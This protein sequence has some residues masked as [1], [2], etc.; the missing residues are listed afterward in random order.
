MNQQ[1]LSRSQ[2]RW[3]RLGLFLS[4][5]PRIKYLLGKAHVVANSLNRSTL[6][7][8]QDQESEQNKKISSNVVKVNATH[9]QD[10]DSE[11]FNL[12]QASSISLSKQ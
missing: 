2:T 7:T 11:F 8:T 12:I 4:I 1:I 5:Q 3:I 6:P 10:Q 9:I